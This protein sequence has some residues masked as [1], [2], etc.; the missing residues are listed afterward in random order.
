LIR[1]SVF[2]PVR[3]G[4]PYV[5]E[6]VE[7][8]LGQSYP[9]LELTVL[10]N[11]SSDDTVPWVRSIA[12]PRLRVTT[13]SQPL[14]IEQS[15]ARIK[16]CSKLEYSTMIGHDDVLD[17]HFLET[18]RRL[19]ERHPQASLYQT[20]ARL[21]N[22]AGK[23]IRGC[24]PVPERET[25]ADYLRA[26]LELRRDVFGS[27]FVMRSADYDRVGGIPAF[28]RLFFAD[29]A[30]WLS[31]M[32]GS[33]KAADPSEACGVRIHP[34]SESASLPF[35]WRPMLI[36]LGQFSEFL[37]ALREKDD[38]CREV[39]DRLLAPF[40]FNRHR[41]AYVYALLEACGNGRKLETSTVRAIEESLVRTAPGNARTLNDSVTV[42]LLRTANA[43]RMRRPVVWLWALYYRL[44]TRGNG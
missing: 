24:V 28:E 20:G 23:R 18:I 13:S 12:D 5:K 4:W 22:G 14:S 19:I 11:Q 42:K 10:D 27:G 6:C 35:I 40:M 16:D 26:R 1:F 32:S 43:L 30:L 25:A 41:A 38:A 33:Y 21:I 31:L 37:G 8:V 29:D 2:L 39:L 44:S 9:N 34:K 17:R 3:N 7:S 36:S 15:W